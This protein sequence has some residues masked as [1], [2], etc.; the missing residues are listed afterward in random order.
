MNKIQSQNCETCGVVE[1]M[2]HL[3]KCVRNRN[4]RNILFRQLNLNAGNMST[5]H[6]IL[7]APCSGEAKALFSFVKNSLFKG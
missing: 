4:E 6:E 3:L 7:F 1:D 2:H 5:F